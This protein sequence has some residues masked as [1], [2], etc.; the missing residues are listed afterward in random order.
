MKERYQFNFLDMMD[1][2]TKTT[3]ISY[4]V[5]KMKTEF[6]ARVEY[7]EFKYADDLSDLRYKDALNIAET[8]ILD[9]LFLL[10]VKMLKEH[11]NLVDFVV[12]T[13][14][15]LAD[16]FPESKFKEYESA[17]ASKLLNPLL[18]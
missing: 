3:I 5:N 12:I 2:I 11:Q 13:I 7:G 8:V 14:R 1:E 6:S 16:I 17:S 15:L 4:I 18:K 10:P 9:T